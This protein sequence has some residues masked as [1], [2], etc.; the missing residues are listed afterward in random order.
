MSTARFILR[1]AVS[2]KQAAGGGKIVIQATS[3]LSLNSL[4]RVFRKPGLI[5]PKTPTFSKRRPALIPNNPWISRPPSKRCSRGKKLSS[6][7]MA[8]LFVML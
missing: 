1:L 7:S 6:A 2:S 4:V 5:L 8:K 3:L